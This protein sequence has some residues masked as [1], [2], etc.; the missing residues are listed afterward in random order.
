M[1]EIEIRFASTDNTSS[2]R[3][4]V[5][6]PDGLGEGFLQPET[7]PQKTPTTLND[8]SPQTETATQTPAQSDAN[9]QGNAPSAQPLGIIQI[10][11]GMAEHIER[12][13]DFADY[14][15]K[16][17]FIVCGHDHI[18][19]GK[20]VASEEDLGVIPLN[21]KTIMVEDAHVLRLLV[22]SRYKALESPGQLKGEGAKSKASELEEGVC[23]SLPYCMFGHSMG[24]FIL[25]NYLAVHA[26]GVAAA[27]ICGTGHLSPTLSGAGHFISRLLHTFKGPLHRSTM[28]H[29]MSVGAYAKAIEG[30]TS[31]LDWLST[32]EEVVAAYSADPYSG[33]MFSTGGNAALTELTSA[34]VKR[35]TVEAVPNDLPLLFVAGKEDPVGEK[36][37]AVKR[38][39]ALFEDTGHHKVTLVL[40]D[41]MRHE[42]LNERGNESVYDDIITWTVEQLPSR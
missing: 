7:S 22:Q 39:V 42:I 23:G 26:E 24:S 34:M 3:A 28:L 2:I 10:L 38:A 40:Y 37:E 11:H 41:G 14:C 1:K 35:E 19:H 15:T 30:A 17:G 36:G 21:G 29:N 13:R 9:A 25:R 20:S 6:E 4:L 18:G 31:P 16:R 27:I 8:V 32:D 33:F 5:W 12:Y